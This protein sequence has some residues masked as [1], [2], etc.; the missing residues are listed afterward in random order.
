MKRFWAR[1][2]MHLAG[3][4]PA[5]RLAVRIASWGAPP[6][7]ARA[8]LA[9]MSPRGYLAPTAIIHHSEL[10]LGRNVFI[11]DRVVIFQHD[12][13]GPVRLGDRVHLHS[14]TIIE[15]G[16]GGSLTIGADTHVQPRCHFTAFAAPIEVGSGVQ[17]APGCAFYPY[18]HGF[19]PG[20]PIREQVLRTKGGIT[21]CDDAWLGVGVIVLSG[22]RIGRGAVIGAG[23]VVT[24]DIPDGV[25]AAG[26]PARVIKVRGQER[27]QQSRSLSR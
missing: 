24:H 21:V 12:S 1:A 17:I 2:W 7:K 20:T 18:D 4:G 13:G 11:G 22:V 10:K 14:D 9:Q 16:P 15:T 26:V 25:I 5:G 19:E 23:S 3:R 8:F 27:T 6:Y